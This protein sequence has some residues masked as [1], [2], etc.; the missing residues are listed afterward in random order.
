MKTVLLTAVVLSISSCTKNN[1]QENNNELAA[2]RIDQRNELHITAEFEAVIPGVDY[3]TDIALPDNLKHKKVLVITNKSGIH[4]KQRII[5]DNFAKISDPV[6]GVDYPTD[7]AMPKK[8]MGK[9]ILVLREDY[10]L[11]IDIQKAEAGVDFPTETHKEFLVWAFSK[12][13]RIK[14]SSISAIEED[15]GSTNFLAI[16]IDSEEMKVVQIP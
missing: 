14:L 3:P 8:L 11:V 12:T 13:N 1:S 16:T 6:A 10:R 2:Q 7:I 5:I 9:K 4:E 15:V